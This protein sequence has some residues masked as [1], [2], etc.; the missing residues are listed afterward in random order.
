MEKAFVIVKILLIIVSMEWG[1]N[2][3]GLVSKILSMKEKNDLRAIDIA[4]RFVYQL[5]N[6]IEYMFLLLLLLISI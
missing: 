5:F 2:P 6:K 3:G 1:E 4:I